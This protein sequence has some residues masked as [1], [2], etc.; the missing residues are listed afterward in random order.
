MTNQII[1]ML[2]FDA[3][4]PS[5]GNSDRRGYGNNRYIYSN[6]RQ[7]LNSPAAAG[8]WYTA[9]HSAD[10]TPDSSHV[11][12][13]VNPY[14]G[15][16]GFL[17]AFT[18]NERAALLNTTITVGKSSTDGGGTETCT[19]KIFPLSCTEVG[20]SGDH[21]CGSKLAI[22]SD[23]NSRIATV[24][25]SCV[26][27][28]NYS[29]NP[30][31]GAAWYYWLRD[32]YAGS[33]YG[34]RFVS[35]GGTLGWNDACF[36]NYG[37]R[38][39][40]NLSSD[41]LISDSVDSDGCY[42]VIYNQAPTAPSSITVPSEV[43]G[44]ENLSISWAASTDPDGNLSGYVLERKVGSGT[45]AQVYKGS[46]RT[47]TDTITYGWTSVQY[48]VKAYDAAGAESAYTTSATRTVTNNQPPVISGTD[49]ALGSFS[50]AA[51]SYE[52]TVTDADGHQVTVVEKL[53]TTTLRTYT[54]T[55]GDTNE[56]EIT[57]D[58]WLKLLNGDHTLTI[59]AT[60]AK[61][62]S[63]VR[64]LSFDKAMHSVE[65]EQT[66]AM[67]ADDMPTKAL[68]NIQGSFPTGST[69]QVWICNNGND[70][71]PTWED[72]TTKALTSQK[73]FFTNQTKTAASW[74]VKIKVKLLRGSAE[75]DC[76]IQSVGGN[77]A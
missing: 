57:A 36:G 56:L 11:W 65:F 2:C 21:V 46:A 12:N 43:L 34:A 68:V 22:F 25:A 52:Y 48:R 71:E 16:A 51:P 39:A 73:H 14:S 54:A 40:C 70:A 69:L 37:L 67:A 59:T 26:A 7:W 44:G 27:N 53:D 20:L 50:T 55:L 45:W 49:G 63:T 10:Q 42:T 8:Q 38:P 35:S 32:A 58:Q 15:L 6:L 76:Y 30:G 72:I 60:D 47:Y 23:N 4:E 62:E 5:N 31:S 77:F 75:G 19:D 18:A 61:N 64:T 13:G 41:L 74:G 33:A 17:N 24:T 29:S 66:V 1:K 3:T 9:Q 28:S